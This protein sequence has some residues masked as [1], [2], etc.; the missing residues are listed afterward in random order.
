[1]G[2]KRDARLRI[3]GVFRHW[4]WILALLIA[5]V[6]GFFSAELPGVYTFGNLLNQTRVYMVDV[7]FMALGMPD[8]AGAGRH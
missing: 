5:L 6:Y 7:G 3:P 8:G 2:G 4:E 1:M